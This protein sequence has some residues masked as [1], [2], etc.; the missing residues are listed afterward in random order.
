MDLAGVS[1]AI[2]STN[3]AYGVGGWTSSGWYGARPGGSLQVNDDVLNFY[4]FGGGSN[5]PTEVFRIS[6][7]GNVGI[8]TAAGP[9]PGLLQVSQRTTGYGTVATNGSITLT[10]TG[11]QFLNTFKVGDTITVSGETVRTI[12][13]IA[14]NNSLTVSS[15][16]STTASG[17]SYTLVLG[18]LVR[19]QLSR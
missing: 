14:S 10:G 6:A 3:R 2:L 12:A 18:I 9:P 4:Q 7:G 8:G 13:T 19:L 15:A 5:A 1:F 17:L 11:T 16:F